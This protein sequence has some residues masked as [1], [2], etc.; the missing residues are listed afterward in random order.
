MR[1]PVQVTQAL[2]DGRDQQFQRG[3]LVQ[4]EGVPQIGGWDVVQ[5]RCRQAA[6]VGG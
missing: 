6:Q 1:G 4:A 3:L 2:M 5:L